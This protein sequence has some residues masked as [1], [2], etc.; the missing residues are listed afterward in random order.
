MLFEVDKEQPMAMLSHE[1]GRCPYC[2]SQSIDYAPVEIKQMSYGIHFKATCCD[3]LNE[4]KTWYEIRFHECWGHPLKEGL[5]Y[6]DRITKQ[7]EI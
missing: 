2:G 3:C 1:E 4:F 5:L 6:N 7:L